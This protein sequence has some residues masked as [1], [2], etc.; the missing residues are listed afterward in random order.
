MTRP[1]ARRDAEAFADALEGRGRLEGEIRELV[2]CA[3]SLC[4]A[5]AAEPSSKFVLNLRAD[6]MRDAPSVLSVKEKRPRVAESTPTP[7]PHPLRRRIAALAMGLIVAVGGAGLVTSSANA[8]PGEML[9]PIKLGVESFELSLHRANVS[10]GNFQLDL[11]RERL[12]EASSIAAEGGA[13][14]TNLLANTLDAFSD[15][16]FAG[17]GD[18]FADYTDG[19]S[20]AS[21]ETVYAFAVESSRALSL[22]AESVPADAAGA[23]D[24]AV[25]TVSQMATQASTL[26]TE[27]DQDL[28]ESLKA[29]V[30]KAIADRNPQQPQTSVGP[31]VL[32]SVNPSGTVTPT[33]EKPIV[34]PPQTEPPES[35]PDVSDPLTDTLLGNE[36]QTGLIPGLLGGLSGN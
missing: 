3:E 23:F 29:D 6:L 33:T 32:P 25:D 30:E 26:C 12:S 21:V 14:S 8:L 15:K 9:Y 16:A 5:A 24:I 18:L 7:T 36:D 35:V 31:G 13:N 17:S 22:L 27:C 28:V 11:A 19:G 34:A 10:H 1:W 4:K 2:Q 20:I